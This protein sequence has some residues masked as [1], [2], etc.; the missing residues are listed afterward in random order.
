MRDSRNVLEAALAA[1]EPGAAQPVVAFLREH[2]V[3]DVDLQK[4]ADR[5]GGGG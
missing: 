4:L 5:L 3:Q 2:Q 1:H